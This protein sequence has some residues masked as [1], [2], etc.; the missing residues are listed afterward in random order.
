MNIMKFKTSLKE[1]ILD[2][3]DDVLSKGDSSLRQLV[4]DFLS[5][6]YNYSGTKNWQISDTPNKKGLYEVSCHSALGII[7]MNLH[8]EELTNGLFEFIECESFICSDNKYLK[9]LKGSPRLVHDYFNCSHCPNLTSLKGCPR[10]VKTFF[11][12]E[13]GK[14]FTESEVKKFCNVDK[15]RIQV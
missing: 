10:K 12:Q 13:C 15:N 6:N 11:C 14:K 5:A 1:S 3:I 9:T 4:I 2:N 8:L 7:L